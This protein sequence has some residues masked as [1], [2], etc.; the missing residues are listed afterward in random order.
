MY[1]IR[2]YYERSFFA[3]NQIALSFQMVKNPQSAISEAQEMVMKTVNES[4]TSTM[5]QSE[6][7][8]A[9]LD[10]HKYHQAQQQQHENLWLNTVDAAETEQ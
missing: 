10:D 5:S 7:F 9:W 1:A 3:L 4:H 6:I 2:S 8:S